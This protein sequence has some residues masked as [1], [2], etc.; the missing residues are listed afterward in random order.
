MKSVQV[1]YHEVMLLNKLRDAIVT[2]DEIVDALRGKDSALSVKDRLGNWVSPAEEL[3][4]RIEVYGIDKGV[5][6]NIRMLADALAEKRSDIA[7][8][9][10]YMADNDGELPDYCPLHKMIERRF[11]KCKVPEGATEAMYD[12]LITEIEFKLPDGTWVTPH[13]EYED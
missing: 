4:N 1:G 12:T 10:Y 7:E 6:E 2:T 3:A 9:L 13:H 5:L 11:I 8:I